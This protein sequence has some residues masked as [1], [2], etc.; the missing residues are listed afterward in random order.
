[1][2]IQGASP[3]NKTAEAKPQPGK[4]GP[5]EAQE[6]SPREAADGNQP[7]MIKEEE[8]LADKSLSA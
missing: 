5:L 7:D 3:A 8:Q 6:A 4:S 1:M 2:Q